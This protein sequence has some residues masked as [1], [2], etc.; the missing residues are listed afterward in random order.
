MQ[1]QP[2]QV[3]RLLV[4]QYLSCAKK[5]TSKSSYHGLQFPLVPTLARFY[6]VL[7][8]VD[9]SGFTALSQRYLLD[10]SGMHEEINH[11]FIIMIE[12]VSKYGGDVIKF[13]GD[14]MFIVWKF[15]RGLSP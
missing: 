8:N 9:I 4:E 6:G 3:P 15:S 10:V 12:I 5:Y 2:N 1:N 11:Y 13:A 7:L 14:S